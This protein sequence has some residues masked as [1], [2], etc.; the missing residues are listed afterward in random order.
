MDPGTLTDQKPM[1]PPEMKR[2]NS[3][4]IPGMTAGVSSRAVFP[5]PFAQRAYTNDADRISNVNQ[6]EQ[7]SSSSPRTRGLRSSGSGRDS[8]TM[9]TSG[10][11]LLGARDDDVELPG[12]LVF[13]EGWKEESYLAVR[14][15]L[16]TAGMTKPPPPKEMS[17]EEMGKPNSTKGD[18]KG[19]GPLVKTK[20]V[21]APRLK[22][23]R[24]TTSPAGT[25][26]AGV[27]QPL[28]SSPPPQRYRHVKK[29]SQQQQ[30]QHNNTSPS[31]SSLALQQPASA[32]V[33]MP[34]SPS[35]A[36]AAPSA[37]P[38][39]RTIN[40]QL[41]AEAPRGPSPSFAICTVKEA[42]RLFS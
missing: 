16:E 1:S 17:K 3:V 27:A 7:S 6:Q 29:K 39:K 2:M 5:A 4:N 31:R 32:R 26:C 14:A 12:H 34:L 21:L 9:R 41:K 20:A 36:M 30:Q 38:G 18:A 33:A 25:S 35:P 40:L 13:G 28:T 24:D 8:P 15:S 23:H 37:G 19:M 22:Y 42:P 10:F 11:G